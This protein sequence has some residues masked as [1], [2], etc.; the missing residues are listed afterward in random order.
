MTSG[1]AAR[2]RE[3][4]QQGFLAQPLSQR[5]ATLRASATL[6]AWDTRPTSPLVAP[7]FGGSRLFFCICLEAERP[8]SG[9]R[10]V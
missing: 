7:T 6:P 2:A 3:G 8:G 1:A 9:R 5:L 10:L 4:L